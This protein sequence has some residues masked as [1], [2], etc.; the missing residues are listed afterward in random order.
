M[1]TEKKAKSRT[2]K[3]TG[4]LTQWVRIVLY[5][6]ISLVGFMC[7]L[8]LVGLLIWKA[9]KLTALGLTGKFYYLILIPLG[10][11]VA[12]FLFGAMK[13]YAWYTGEGFGG[14]LELGGPIVACAMVVIGGFWLVPDVATFPVTVYVHGE[15]GPDNIV[16]KSTCYVLLDL[17]PD[18]RREPIGDKGQAYFPAIPA[19]FRGQEVIISL[20]SDT[21][22][23][24]NQGQKHK[25][26]GSSLYLPI[27]KKSGRIYGRVQDETGKPLA[28]VT[29]NITT[30]SLSTK[31][32]E[33]GSFELVIPSEYMHDEFSLQAVADG[34]TPWYGTVITNSNETVVILRKE[35]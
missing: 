13:S 29:I 1:A 21:Y 10:L 33:N 15:S 18:R 12:A 3:K 34:Y 31:T 23:L 9:D 22:E 11:S 8:M 5:A 16:L 35:P 14:K 28:H 7:A 30:V 4:D 24:A 26:G 17:G 19:S 25:L 20:E 27:R 32:D 2:K 6:V